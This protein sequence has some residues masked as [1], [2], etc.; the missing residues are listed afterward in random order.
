MKLS[1]KISSLV[2]LAS[3]IPAIT[4]L[5]Y[6][7]RTIEQERH[8]SVL[9]DVLHRVVLSTELLSTELDSTRREVEIY[10][11]LPEIKSMDPRQFLP[12][13]KQELE[14]HD[15][16]YEKFIVGT[17]KGYFYNTAGGNPDKGM[18]R[19]F[20]DKDPESAPRNIRKRDYWQGTVGSNIEQAEVSVISAPMISYTTGARQV[21]VATTIEDQGELKGML[22]ASIDWDRIVALINKIKA[23]EFSDYDW[24]PNMFL[25]GQDGSY[26]YHWDP[27]RI[28]RLA[29][30][31][32]GEL[33]RTE[34]GQTITR[35]FSLADEKISLLDREINKITAGETGHLRYQNPQ[36]KDFYYLFYSPVRA[37]GYSLGLIVKDDELTPPIVDILSIVYSFLFS[38]AAVLIAASI[39]NRQVISAP[40]NQL[41]SFIGQLRDGNYDQKLNLPTN[42]ELKQVASTLNDMSAAIIGREKALRESEIRF[43]CAMAGTNDG[44]W[45]WDLNTNNVY[46][47]PRWLEMLGYGAEELPHVLDTFNK[48]QH[49][50]DKEYIAHYLKELLE[51]K[52]DSYHLIMRMVHKNGSTVHILSRAFMVK[53]EGTGRLI[54]LIGTHV[55]I[56]DEKLHE[57][58]IE[59]LNADLEK[60][61]EQRTR[62]LEDVNQKL[63]ALSML[64]GLTQIG[65]RRAMEMR[66]N[67]THSAFL[68]HQRK[69]S[70]LLL[71]IDHFK[72]YNDHY[73]H[74]MGDEAL[75]KIAALLS[76]SIRTEDQ[77]FRYGGE[78]FLVI[79]PDSDNI[80]AS[81]IAKRVVTNI[82][83][84]KEPH[85]ES[86]FGY[87]TVSAGIATSGEKDLDWN[88]I[89]K[90]ADER[91]YL[92]KEN[93][94]NQMVGESPVLDIAKTV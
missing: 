20:N 87:I 70:V 32:N 3:L 90:R 62:E 94:R 34:D 27:N 77:L 26:W 11:H 64:D 59:R 19:T 69:Y 44:L 50:D 28:V 51:G 57:E 68:R 35:R 1:V 78:E 47:S 72:P 65:N 22:G 83:I 18:L 67:H 39:W 14:H 23:R 53:E 9:R 48:L 74:Q 71:D 25:L 76:E 84:A 66:I 31:D 6:T 12:M 45:D 37:A 60:R 16:Y 56:T 13:L 15:Q 29:K 2:V 46:Y 43:E 80:S 40:I 5:T 17:P 82:E 75:R 41:M 33:L 91:L 36:N 89:I 55:D 61:V 85:S 73:G 24:N 81:V 58:E 30:D 52:H 88:S 93:G 79:L 86:P 4:V 38:L 54:R 92:A 42:D 63:E 21:V 8:Q 10:A 7:L 49:P